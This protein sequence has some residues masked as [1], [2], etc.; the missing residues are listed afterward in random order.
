[1]AEEDDFIFLQASQLYEE[2]VSK[3]LNDNVDDPVSEELRLKEKYAHLEDDDFVLDKLMEDIPT[4]ERFDKPV[5]ES[6]IL[7]KINDR[8][9][10]AMKNSTA[11]AVKLWDCWRGSRALQGGETSTEATPSLDV[12]SNEE[13]N[14]WL[15][16]FVLEVKTKKGEKY[17]G[18]TLYALCAGIQRHIREKRSL[19]ADKNQQLDIYKDNSFVYFR[20]V[21]DSELKLLHC[22]GTGLTTRNKLHNSS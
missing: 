21:L 1:M 10:R 8:I 22:Q 3:S 2:S 9:P 18:A 12:I 4:T 16:R 11:W 19:S 20:N 7:E 14:H 6:D 15:A 13:L 17:R 5:S